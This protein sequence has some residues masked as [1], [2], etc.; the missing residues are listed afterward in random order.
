MA[1][2]IELQSDNTEVLT[3]TIPHSQPQP[4]TKDKSR[5]QTQYQGLCMG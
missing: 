1:K 2:S 4:H 5:K 3:E